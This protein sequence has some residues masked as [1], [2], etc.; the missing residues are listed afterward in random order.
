MRRSYRADNRSNTD[1]VVCSGRA[2]VERLVVAR[3]GNERS[4][5]VMMEEDRML[6]ARG[7]LTTGT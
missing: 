5:S 2:R 6:Q 4:E 1:Q 3:A 7:S